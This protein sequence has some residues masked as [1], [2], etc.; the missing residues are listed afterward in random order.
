MKGH[1][2]SI[3]GILLLSVLLVINSPAAITVNGIADQEIE[4]DQ[5][6][7]TVPS[8]AGFTI[9][10]Q[11]N[12]TPVVLDANTVVSMPGYY[13][14]GVSKTN[15]SDA[16]EE[17]ITIQF[18]VLDS[19]R[20]TS[21]RGL[22]NWTP[23]PTIDSAPQAFVGMGMEV[24]APSALPL[25]FEIPLMVRLFDPESGRG[26]RL[27]GKVE[28]PE[29]AGA[30]VQV[31][32]GF[33]SGFLPAPAGSGTL[34]LTPT[35]NG[36]VVP[37]TVQI[38]PVTTWTTVSSDLTQSVD[39]GPNARVS[40]TA[41]MT[42]SDGVTLTIGPGSVIQIAPGVDLQL[43]GRLEVKGTASA[44]V[45]F[46]NVPGQDP[47]GGFLLQGANSEVAADYAIFTGS[48]ADQDWFS[49]SGYSAHRKEQATFLLDDSPGDFNRCYFIDLAGQALHG[50]NAVISLSDCIVQRVPT[51]GQFNGGAVTVTRSALLEFPK[52][53]NIFAD[54]DNDGIHGGIPSADRL[55]DRLGQG[56]R[57]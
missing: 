23:S 14:L 22:I 30:S 41:D 44:P 51:V 1:P 11:L 13:E 52:N 39:W 9:V 20:G 32:R 42:V 2:H 53:D 10:A 46:C 6:S 49:D 27:N 19:T 48:G 47:W 36:I 8:E 15:D 28:V 25:G 54:D 24:V 26:L 38:E 4:N 45:L 35:L 57:G 34:S 12:G 37:T 31:L 29:I 40:I 50:R 55:R 33:G 56:R 3:F 18:I 7:F 21:E 43:D 5:A 16:S 17:S